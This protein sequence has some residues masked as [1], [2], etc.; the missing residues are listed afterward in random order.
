[1]KSFKVFLYATVL[2]VLAST[3]ARAQLEACVVTY[4]DYALDTTTEFE[5]EAW[6]WVEDYFAYG[7]C[8]GTAYF[9][10][11]YWEHS[12]SAA[13]QILSPAQAP[14]YD[15]DSLADVPYGG[16]SALAST[17]KLIADDFG[18][19]IIYWW[20]RIFCNIPEDYFIDFFDG[21]PLQVPPC[22][23]ADISGYDFHRNNFSHRNADYRSRYV[24]SS[25]LPREFRFTFRP[26][27]DPT[28]Y[29]NKA[30]FDDGAA[31]WDMRFPA[32]C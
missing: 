7:E 9:Q 14:A 4:T 21:Q 23:T 10:W 29:G 15:D 8:F 6:G 13:V 30:P 18:E 28:F 3:P 12:Y 2:F 27:D 22:T 5:V 19:Y 32:L 17:S 11:G 25:S 1:M 24:F 31:M 16:G 20:L 26:L